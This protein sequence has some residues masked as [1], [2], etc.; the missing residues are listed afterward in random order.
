[1]IQNFWNCFGGQR[2]EDFIMLS[3]QFDNHDRSQNKEQGK[4][5]ELDS[6]RRTKA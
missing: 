3:L 1:M 4:G 2:Y 6:F 5:C